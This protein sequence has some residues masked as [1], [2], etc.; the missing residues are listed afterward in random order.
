MEILEQPTPKG[1]PDLLGSVRE[2]VSI[3]VMA[4][5]SLM[6]LRDAFRLARGDLADMVRGFLP[7]AE[8]TFKHETGG[9]EKSG[10]FL[11]ENSRLVEEY[12]LQY[13]PFR[14]RVLQIINEVRAQ[15]GQ[16][17]IADG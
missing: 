1:E 7:K 10:N 11:I 5:E 9:R 4:D 13:A 2:G 14:Q 12:G 15:D 17:P 6:N 16:A 3:P 8:I